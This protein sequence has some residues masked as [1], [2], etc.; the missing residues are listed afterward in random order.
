MASEGRAAWRGVAELLEKMTSYHDTV[1]ERV[2]IYADG[3]RG[4]DRRITFLRVQMAL[5]AMF[6]SFDLD[7]IQSNVATLSQ[8]LVCWVSV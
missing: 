5:V 1:P 6:L 8:I 2:Y 4:G 7:E 3:G